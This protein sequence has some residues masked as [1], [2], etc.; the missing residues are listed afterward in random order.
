[1]AHKVCAIM[2]DSF[3]FNFSNFLCLAR[4][5]NPYVNCLT[6]FLLVTQFFFALQELKLFNFVSLWLF[7]VPG[8]THHFALCNRCFGKN[9]TRIQTHSAE[10]AICFDKGDLFPQISRTKRQHFCP[11]GRFL[12]QLLSFNATRVLPG[13][14]VLL[15]GKY[16]L[17]L[18]KACF[19]TMR[20]LTNVFLE[21]DV[22]CHSPVLKFSQNT[23][24]L[25]AQRPY[26]QNYERNRVLRSHLLVSSES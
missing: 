3:L 10:I 19:W 5:V 8:F 20:M 1:M 24:Q 21:P 12:K 13:K 14:L 4:L 16:T 7:Q 6:T 25:Q 26:T 17:K 2:R 23:E 11:Q 9:A 22:H 18:L 15:L